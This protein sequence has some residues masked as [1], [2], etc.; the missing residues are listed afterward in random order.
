VEIKI[1]FDVERVVALLVE[2]VQTL[3]PALAAN[4]DQVQRV[5]QR[6]RV[7]VRVTVPV[8]A[9]EASHVFGGQTSAVVVVPRMSAARTN[10][11]DR[12][13]QTSFA[14]FGKKSWWKSLST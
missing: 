5:D 11:A 4:A 13:V 2:V 7:A 6:R 10:V 14:L 1:I 8:S 3:F 12:T 9:V